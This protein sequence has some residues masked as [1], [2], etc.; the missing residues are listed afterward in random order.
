MGSDRSL[1]LETAENKRKAN[2]L[3]TSNT[4]LQVVPGGHFSADH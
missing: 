4:L 3:P 1:L 2:V